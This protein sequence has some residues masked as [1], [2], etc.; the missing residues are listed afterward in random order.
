MYL[1]LLSYAEYITAYKTF[2]FDVAKI[3][4]GELGSS[5]SDEDIMTDVEKAFEFERS[6][7]LVDDFNF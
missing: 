4:A 5:V 6:M 3:V 2:M 7:A 1:D